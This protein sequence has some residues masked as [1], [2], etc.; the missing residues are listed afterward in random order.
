M[1]RVLL[2]SAPCVTR[3]A[4]LLYIPVAHENFYSY[5]GSYNPRRQTA[6]WWTAYATGLYERLA[7]ERWHFLVDFKLIMHLAPVKAQA[8]VDYSYLFNMLA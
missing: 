6:V 1:G 4:G 7:Q 5:C 8:T 3:F 2:E